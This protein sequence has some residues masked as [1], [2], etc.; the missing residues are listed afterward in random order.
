MTRRR[1]L[2]RVRLLLA[3][4]HATSNPYVVVPWLLAQ[5]LARRVDVALLQEVTDRHARL[6]SLLPRWELVRDGDE[7]IL[8]RRRHLEDGFV[9]RDASTSWR[10]H[11]TGEDH[12]PRT[13][14]FGLVRGWLN[15]ISVHYPPGWEAGPQDRRQAGAAYTRRLEVLL[16]DL[17]GAVLAGGDWNA[18]RGSRLLRASW[19]SLGLRSY[20]AGIDYVAASLKVRV[21][22]YRRIGR[23]RGMDHDAVLVVA[24]P[25]HPRHTHTR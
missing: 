14:P 12:K 3:N 6:L 4:L 11:H 7:A 19:H 8:G 18:L 1:R 25:S 22:R 16:E 13:I 21:T 17:G 23:A 24:R 9:V 2:L 20:G 10:G 5:L 15:V